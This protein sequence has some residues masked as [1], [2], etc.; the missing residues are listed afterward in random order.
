MSSWISFKFRRNFSRWNV[1]LQTI[2][3]WEWIRFG[4]R[5][6]AASFLW[7]VRTWKIREF[8]KLRSPWNVSIP[9]ANF[10]RGKCF[11]SI[12]DRSKLWQF[13]ARNWCP[14]PPLCKIGG[15]QPVQRPA[16]AASSITK[17]SLKQL[18]AAARKP[19][20]PGVFGCPFN[21]GG[22]PTQ[23]FD[24]R[25]KIRA[26]IWGF[27]PG[28]AGSTPN[29]NFSWISQHEHERWCHKGSDIQYHILAYYAHMWY[30][31]LTN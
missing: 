31:H 15:R 21:Q 16:A 29:R 2:N 6:E 24:G 25:E 20:T 12:L 9:S 1:I 27:Q 26:S 3:V 4:R 8:N 22:H 11:H 23:K 7:T 17:L 19:V 14:G 30:A 10:L 5:L 13:L 18:A 28:I